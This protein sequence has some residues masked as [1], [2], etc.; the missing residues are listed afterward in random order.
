MSNTNTKRIR[1]VDTTLRDGS[2]SISHQ[3]T[4]EQVRNIAQGLDAAGV[5]II[6]ISHGDGLGGSSIQYGLDRTPDE[7]KIK[8]AAA[9]LVH[10][11]IAVLL[12]P[13]I[14]TKEDLTRAYEHGAR[15]ARIATHVTEAD[16]SEQHIGIAKNMGMEVLCFLM[17]AHMIDVPDMLQQAMLLER[18]GADGVYVV[19]SAGAMLPSEV[20]QRVGALVGKLR[21]QVGFHAHNNLGLGVGNTVAA[22]EEGAVLVDGSL[23]GMG[24]GAGNAMTEALVA[25]LNKAGYTTGIDLFKI[26][27]VG[28]RFVK[29]ILSRP[30]EIDNNSLVLGYAG[31]YSTFLLHATKAAEKLGIDARDIIVELGR[32]RT[33]GGQEDA[34]LDVGLE[35]VERRAR[36]SVVQNEKISIV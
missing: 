6:E 14:G 25:V 33:V 12:I 23:R 24:G 1:L 15:I 22:L 31:V 7:E 8:I 17:M 30:Q 26:M 21:I 35:I 34:I 10:S 4:A 16:I 20:R 27:D 18:Y 11:K 13:G 28:E 9:A 2:H 32:R 3:Y 36:M 5:E 29:P 19:D